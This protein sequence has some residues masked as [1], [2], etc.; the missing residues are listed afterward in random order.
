MGNGLKVASLFDRNGRKVTQLLYK[1]NFITTEY[2][3]IIFYIVAR[4][5]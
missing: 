5:R 1:S 3:Y 2:M 4:Q